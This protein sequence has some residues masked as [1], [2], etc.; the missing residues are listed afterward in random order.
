M[1]NRLFPLV[2]LLLL[3]SCKQTKNEDDDSG[4]QEVS[5]QEKA[6]LDG[7]L[8]IYD[9]AG[10]RPLF[11]KNNDTTYIVNFWA[12]WCEPCV[13]ELPYFEEL[14]EKYKDEPVK[15]VLVDLDDDRAWN[16]RLIPFLKKRRLKSTVVILDDPKQNTWIPLVDEQWSGG[17]PATLIY[18]KDDRDF[19]E[20]GFT[21][22][23]LEKALLE[24]HQAK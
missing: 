11:E 2:A 21:Y 16:K 24:I 19:Y 13:A 4:V 18:N 14:G 1:R 10:L 7:K 8:P 12:T 17:I 3:A 15:I 6:F 22:D 5:M 20:Q 9:F 23:E